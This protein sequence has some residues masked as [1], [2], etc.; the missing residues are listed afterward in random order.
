MSPFLPAPTMPILTRFQGTCP[1]SHYLLPIRVE[2]Q[3][4]PWKHLS[5]C[6]G[7]ELCREEMPYS[8]FSPSCATRLYSPILQTDWRPLLP[9][10]MGILARHISNSNLIPGTHG[11]LVVTPQSNLGARHDV[12]MLLEVLCLEATP[13][14]VELTCHTRN[15]LPSQPATWS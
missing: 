8:A 15:Q 10:A 11:S 14:Q 5:L 6:C 1:L 9:L 4:R 12:R 2:I 7:Q 13:G 3:Q